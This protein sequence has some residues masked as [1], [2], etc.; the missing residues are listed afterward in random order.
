MQH[1]HIARMIR[2]AREDIGMSQEALAASVGE[3]AS[4]IAA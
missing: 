2:L 4:S 1:E 3:A